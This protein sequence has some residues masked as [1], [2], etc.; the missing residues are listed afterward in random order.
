MSKH[1]TDLSFCISHSSVTRRNCVWFVSSAALS[2][3]ESEEVGKHWK[4]FF[5]RTIPAE[6]SYCSS[7]LN[8][9]F[10]RSFPHP[11]AMLVLSVF[12]DFVVDLFHERLRG[13]WRGRGNFRQSCQHYLRGWWG[14]F[15]SQTWKPSICTFQWTWQCFSFCLLLY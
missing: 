10:S 4:N 11:L 5:K 7:L 13:V 14:N 6:V 9:S 15:W 3:S 1:L 2:W 12:C 8:W